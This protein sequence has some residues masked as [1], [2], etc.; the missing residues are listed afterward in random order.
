MKKLRN[1][2]K[3]L[4]YIKA[5]KKR[6]RIYFVELVELKY[7]NNPTKLKDEIKEVNKF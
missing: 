4:R 6:M 3:T 2:I 1:A 5:D 7:R